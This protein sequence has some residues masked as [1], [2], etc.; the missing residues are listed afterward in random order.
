MARK[1][2]RKE[3]K[4][5]A[6][7]LAT[8]GDMVTLL[9]T[10]FVLLFAF[11][12]IDV[13]KFKKMMVSFQGALGVLDGGKS[14]QEDP[15]PYGG[16]SGYDAGEERRQTQSTFQVDRELRSFLKDQEMEQ[17]VSV[18][19]DQRGVT[20][21]LSDQL[22]FPLG[23]VDIRPEGKRLLAKL[24]EFL[25]GRIPALA[26][27]GHTDDRPLRGGPYRD[28]WGLSAIRAAIVASYLVDAAGISPSIVQAVGYG[29]FRP[30]VPND[31]DENRSRNR[32]VDLVILS[33]YP[34]Q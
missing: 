26:V 23:G 24:G 33:K 9:L 27:E 14:L 4:G 8:Y 18:I 3:E 32:R 30:V 7:W 28:N 15:L 11:S 13:E 31:S 29:P 20:V 22:L 6:G 5:G 1:K 16:S 25:K 34:K 19:V 12:S 17:D 10:F 2:R 21:S